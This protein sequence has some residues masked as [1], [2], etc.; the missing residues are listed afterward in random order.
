MPRLSPRAARKASPKVII[1]S[2]TVWWASIFKSPWH[3]R[4]IE[5]ILCFDNCS[6]IWSKKPIPVEISIGWA[7]SR[8]TL[9]KILVSLL[10]RS[11]SPVRCGIKGVLRSRAA[12]KRLFSATVPADMRKQPSRL[13]FKFRTIMRLSNKCF[14]NA[15]ASLTLISKKFDW[16]G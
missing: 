16:L 3:L 7:W 1:Q 12:S 14:S 6:S 9:A 8:F 13:W 4:V 5:I 15:S 10:V 2:S 11:T